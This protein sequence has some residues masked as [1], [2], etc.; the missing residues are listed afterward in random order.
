MKKWTIILLVMGFLASCK[1]EP[2]ASKEDEIKTESL[3]ESK[4]G[5]YTEWYPGKKQIKFRGG[6]DDKMQ[7][8]GKWSFYSEK[9]E[10]LSVTFYEHG[11]RD[12]FTIVKYPTGGIHY[13]GEYKNDTVVG[14]W[15]TYDPTGKVISEKDYTI[16]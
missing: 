4:D 1:T 10:E 3:T 8:H 15:T 14:V 5:V 13:R 2:K 6:Q 7:R 12:G 9:G 16:K 11:L